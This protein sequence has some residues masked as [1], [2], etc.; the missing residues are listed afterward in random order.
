MW[1]TNYIA[2]ERIKNPVDGNVA[3]S[4]S[5][6]ANIQGAS[7]Y[8]NTKIVVPYGIAY[9]PPLGETG[10]ILPLEN[11]NTLIGV[12]S[13]TDVDLE[14][15]EIM[16]FSQGGAKILLKNNGNVEINGKVI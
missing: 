14:P 10:V 8:N 1:L 11:M 3:A 9:N 15:G 6:A 5:A 2:R 12:Y 16:L 4:S 7:Q 13:N